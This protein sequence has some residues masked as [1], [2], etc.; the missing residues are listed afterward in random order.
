MINVN[1][2]LQEMI[3]C[4][5]KIGYSVE[6][7][8]YE[9]SVHRGIYH[10]SYTVRYYTVWYRGECIDDSTGQPKS[11]TFILEYVFRRELEKRLMS[12]FY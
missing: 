12:L 1:F 5:E 7:K 10:E 4:L 2:S 8:E 6:L 9:D 3:L 11:G